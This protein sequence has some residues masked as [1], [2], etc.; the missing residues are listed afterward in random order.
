MAPLS[1]D[2][3]A[4]DQ[5]NEEK[6]D[7]VVISGMAGRFPESENIYKFKENLYNKVDMV[8]EENKRWDVGKFFI[9][10]FILHNYAK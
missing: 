7:D 2:S 3:C 8:T 6:A 9:Y 4:S 1:T 10:F 5:E